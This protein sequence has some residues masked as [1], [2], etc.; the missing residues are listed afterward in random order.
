MNIVLV[1][2][3]FDLLHPGHKWFLRT[4]AKHGGR[5]VAVIARDANVIKL[6]GRAPVWSEEARLKAVGG[7][8]CV[9]RAV[10]GY[11]D[12]RKRMAI[13]KDIKPDVIVLGYDQRAKIPRGGYKIIRLKAHHP[14]KYK[15][16]LLRKKRG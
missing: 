3:T 8:P 1:F 2:G 4:G 6:K 13:I 10:L 16:T 15:T 11:K 5:L 9:D 14:E 12:W 7:L